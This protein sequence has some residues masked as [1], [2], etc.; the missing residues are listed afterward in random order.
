MMLTFYCELWV[1]CRWPCILYSIPF[2][3]LQGA[4]ADMTSMRLYKRTNKQRAFS[5]LSNKVLV[6]PRFLV[7][8]TIWWQSLSLISKFIGRILMRYSKYAFPIWS[9]LLLRQKKISQLLVFHCAFTA[10]CAQFNFYLTSARA[11]LKPR[12]IFV[13]PFARISSCF[14]TKSEWTFEKDFAVINSK[15]FIDVHAACV[16]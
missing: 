1:K 2:M 16:P 11:R 10:Y 4:R 14:R 5:Q 12:R 3:I 7:L 13:D 8:S 9:S 15:L 6:G